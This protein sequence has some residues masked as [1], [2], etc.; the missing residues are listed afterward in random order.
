VVIVY[1]WIGGTEEELEYAGAVVAEQGGSE[2]M[3]VMAAAEALL[4]EIVGHAVLLDVAD[5]GREFYYVGWSDIADFYGKAVSLEMAQAE[6]VAVTDGPFDGHSWEME[7][8]DGGFGCAGDGKYLA[9]DGVCVFETGISDVA[10]VDI[11]RAGDFVDGVEGCGADFF[12]FAVDVFA[13]AGG[14]VEGDFLYEEVFGALFKGA[15][16]AGEVGGGV[17]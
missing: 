4:A 6:F 14:F 9:G 3:I 15:A 7:I 11:E 8:H 16:Y 2:E 1:R 17:W 5:E 10:L 12:D 13:L